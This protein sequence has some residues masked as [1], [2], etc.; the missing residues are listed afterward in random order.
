[1]ALSEV[2]PE[3][4]IG[5]LGDE[6]AQDLLLRNECFR[7]YAEE[8]YGVP[9]KLFTFNDYSGTMEAMLGAHLDFAWLGSSGYAGIYIEDPEAV[10]PVLTHMQP[11][12]E[13]GYYSVMIARADSGIA[14]LADMEGKR[15]GFA[16]PNST[17]GF[18]IPMIE[19]TEAPYSLDLNNYFAS[20]EF[21]GGHENGVLSVLRGELDATVTWVSGIGDWSR[22]YSSGN[23][24]KMVD[25]GVLNM[26][27]IIQIWSSKL[28]PNGPVV[29]PRRLP[30][31]ARSVMLGMLRWILENDPDC[32]AQI[33]NGTIKAWVPVDHGFYET[34]VRAR[35]TKIEQGA[36]R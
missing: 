11:T 23:L 10:V 21:T 2:Q 15:L 1:M 18:L 27:D 33:A 25:K 14:S 6:A 7:A 36:G 17:S 26:D 31:E 20:T 13:T 29:M 24:R 3:F 34:I 16:D 28:I 8:A 12:G 4:R 22:G 30:E 35:L 32:N 9:V 19:L 5:F